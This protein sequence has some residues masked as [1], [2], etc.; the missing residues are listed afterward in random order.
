MKVKQVLRWV[1]VFIVCVTLNAHTVRP[2]AVAMPAATYYVATDG[3]DAAGRGTEA[4]PWR[5]IPYALGQVPDGSTILVKPGE[6]VGEIN[7]NGYFTQGVVVRSQ[8]PYQARLR[9]SPE[10]VIHTYDGCRGITLEGF[11]IA[12]SPAAGPLVVHIEGG[13]SL[14]NVSHIVLANNVFHD[15]YDNDILKI[16]YSAS[17]ITV[18][19]NMFYNQSGSDEHMDINSVTDVIIEDNVFFNDFAGSGRPAGNTSAFINIKDSADDDD[20]TGSSQITVRRNVFLNWEGN[21]NYG[22]IQ[23]SE[24]SMPYYESYDVLIENNLMLGNAPGVMRAPVS[25]QGTRDVTFRNNT[26]AGNLPSAAY[27]LSLYEWDGSLI[28]QNVSYYNNIWA[29]PTGTMGTEYEED[30]DFSMTPPGATQSAVLDNNLYWNGGQ[31]IPVDANAAL[32]YT[33]DAHRLV[34]NPLLGSQAGLAVPRWL[35]GE[36]RFADG[37]ASIRE[38]FER[39]VTHYGT[40]GTGSQAIDAADPANAPTDDILGRTRSAPDLGAVEAASAPSPDFTLEATP[41]TQRILPGGQAVYT[42]SLQPGGGFSSTVT[43]TA[44]DPSADLEI[45]IHPGSLTL[46]GQ[47]TLTVT[48]QHGAPLS[49]VIGYTIAI[50]GTGGGLSHS[51]SVELRVGSNQAPTA[52]GSPD[53]ANNATEVPVGKAFS[54]QA[55]DADGDTLTYQV[56]LGTANPPANVANVTSPS[57]APNLAT[58]TTYY[59]QISASDGISTTAGPV[60]QFTTSENVPTYLPLIRRDNAGTGGGSLSGCRLFPSDHILNTPIDSLPVDANSSAYINTIGRDAHFHADF[61]SGTWEGFAIGIP[62]NIV[63]GTQ[64][65]SSVLFQYGDESDPG[66]YPIPANPLIE[67]DPNSGD[68]HILIVENT[69]CILY[70][71]SAMYRTG[72][73]WYGDAGA[74]F[75]LNDYTLR[76]DSWTSADAAGLP[77]L[78]LLVRYDEVAAGEIRHAIRFTAPQTRASYVWP[79]RHEASD[80]TGTQYPPMGQRFRLKAGYDISG[81]SPQMQVI[82]QAM[83]TYGIILADNGSRW[84]VSGAPDERWDNDMLHEMDVLTGDDFEA[85]D[86]SSLQIDPNS[87]RARQP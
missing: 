80:Y 79:A 84:Y 7:L 28:N 76:P 37:S 45:A 77:M 11:D 75:D 9:N 13:G 26:I 70:E 40:P 35:P 63:P 73:Q 12:G 51:A 71:L 38:A 49:P 69:N 81:F 54:W 18:R 31:N 10:K 3:I 65:T 67:G 19:G 39:L 57:Y 53:P 16:N 85:V 30:Y 25:A 48:D 24:D 72:S 56:A 5:T 68:R 15:S 66:P 64:A 83:K 82:L 50:T 59:W 27:A 62:Y 32:N 78:P 61:G 21:R 2:A 42:L 17:H 43:L 47:A 41:A 23:L 58:G 44:N 36:G 20:V 46:P 33:D 29:D 8:V 4:Q 34:A 1:A 22:F 52:P 74:I 14:G 60:W 87:G 55:N 6:Y 86:V